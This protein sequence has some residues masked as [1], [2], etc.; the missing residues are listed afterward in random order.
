MPVFVLL[1]SYLIGCF[2]T[3]Y[4]AG[5]LLKGRDIRRLGDGNVGAANAYRE[6]GSLAG[7]GVFL[8]DIV[9]GMVVIGLS[10]ALDVSPVIVLWS[11]VMAVLG[12]SFPVFLHFRGGRG[13]ATAI[14]AL[15]ATLGWPA[16]IATTVGISCLPLFKRVTP[17]SAVGFVLLPVLCWAYGYSWGMV[18]YSVCLPVQVGLTH[19]LRVHAPRALRPA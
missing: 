2:P 4:F 3:A 11:G 14:G 5:R 18:F 1:A 9:K 12:H 17:A 16:V 15:I 8:L 10:R 13:V 19:Y 6:L 7:A